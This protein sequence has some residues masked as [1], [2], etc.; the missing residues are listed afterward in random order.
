MLETV[1]DYALERLDVT[2]EAEATRAAHV[3]YFVALAERAEP[4]LY[5][6]AGAAWL[7]RLETDLDNIRALLAWSTS[8]ADASARE[9]GLRLAVALGD[10]WH[11]RSY[12]AEGRGWLDRL[13]A[14]AG[15]DVSPAIRGKALAAAA[16]LAWAQGDGEVAAALYGEGLTLG[17][18][19]D[20]RFVVA[21]ALQG[22]AR[23]AWLRGDY[24][25]MARYAA[26]SLAGA[27]E[28]GNERR[29][30]VALM[31]LSIATLR[32]QRAEQ[33]EPLLKE[34]LALSRSC[35]F[36]RGIAWALQT[37]AECAEVT[38]RA[39]EAAAYLHESLGVFL[40]A[41]DAWGLFENLSRIAALAG[42]AGRPEDAARLFGAAERL[43]SSLGVAPFAG[44]DA[45][46]QTAEALRAR[47]DP[48]SFAGA[49]AAGEALPPEVAAAEAM[50][51][52]QELATA[53]PPAAP[54]RPAG[55]SEREVEVLRFVARG[56]T[57]AQTAERLFL[58]PRTVDAH[59]RRI[60]DK[61]G[62]ATRAEVVRFAIE[63]D[64][65]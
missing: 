37:L 16:H 3:A 34:A 40:E 51:L 31:L 21:S 9:T 14:A 35:G 12:F 32:Q 46:R 28:L 42:R 6:G 24:A 2:G 50:T 57:N 61:L 4:L 45:H 63:H 7:T 22:L 41:G 64:L 56:L 47:L 54:T 65:A 18:E 11:L 5:G 23:V 19:H 8:R 55:L 30:G 60:Y 17:R 58:S 36:Q 13:L 44:L 62:L 25:A 48:Q 33:A 39:R 10:F 53:A 26:D 59:L 15:P 20:D 27:R 49:V 1:R 38:G 52:A 29:Q 43:R